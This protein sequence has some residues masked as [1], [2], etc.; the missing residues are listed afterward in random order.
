[1]PLSSS[2]Q[3]MTTI[4]MFCLRPHGAFMAN[5]H[6]RYVNN[7]GVLSK[8]H[9]PTYHYDVLGITPKAT[10]KQ[11]KA[12]F[13]RMSKTYHPDS[14]PDVSS[15]EK[16]HEITE[17]YEILGNHFSRRKYDRG[18]LNPTDLKSEQH[19]SGEADDTTF[20]RK[21]FKGRGPIVTGR[22]KYY[23][24]DEYYRQHYGEHVLQQFRKRHGHHSHP[25]SATASLPGDKQA[26]AQ[27]DQLDPPVVSL[28]IFAG[29]IM[30]V[31]GAYFLDNQFIRDLESTPVVLDKNG[32]TSS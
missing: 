29:L 19:A 23:N 10:H 32:K 14:N 13:Y 24:F 2:S 25:S 16:F 18:L 21:N 28:F 1:M 7:T 17:A 6:S 26:N 27:P 9:S 8:R 30:I 31:F 12:A 11:I 20:R 4:R 22:T 5:A 15:T 3:V